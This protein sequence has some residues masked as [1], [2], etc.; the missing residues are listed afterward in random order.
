[1]ADYKFRAKC[2]VSK[3]GVAAWLGLPETHPRVAE[4]HS[5]VSAAVK[6]GIAFPEA[7]SKK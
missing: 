3:K 1:M 4:L 6:N 2:S 5:T 7:Y